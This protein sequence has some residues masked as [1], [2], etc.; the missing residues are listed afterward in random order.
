[1][2]S[3]E[4]EARPRGW[5]YDLMPKVVAKYAS[6]A[7]CHTYTRKV[8]QL[9]AS[10][11]DRAPTWRSGVCGGDWSRAR[12]ARARSEFTVLPCGSPICFCWR[13]MYVTGCGENQPAC[14]LNAAVNI[15]FVRRIRS[16][17][18]LTQS[19]FPFA[20]TH[21]AATTIP[22]LRFRTREGRACGAGAVHSTISARDA[23]WSSS[24]RKDL[25]QQHV[26]QCSRQNGPLGKGMFSFAAPPL[27]MKD[28]MRFG[29]VR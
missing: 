18:K 12:G 6:R 15:K 17:Q 25:R 10:S 9:K 20:R 1:M 11:R 8:A 23:L 27:L 5:R 19:F 16:F 24:R 21:R 14:D 4:S 22:A 29:H 26:Q 13:L 28:R 3:E 7:A 2:E